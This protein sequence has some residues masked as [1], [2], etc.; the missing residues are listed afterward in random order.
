MNPAVGRSWNADSDIAMIG[1]FLDKT[2]DFYAKQGKFANTSAETPKVFYFDG[3]AESL[4]I[5]PRAVFQYGL[6]VQNV[7]NLVYKRFSKYLLADL[8]K[9]LRD[10][11]AKNNTEYAELVAN[12]GIDGIKP[13]DVA[14]NT[15]SEDLIKSTPDI[16]TAP[17]IE[18]FLEDFAGIFNTKILG[19]ELAAIHNAG[20]YNSGGTVNADLGATQIAI[21]DEVAANILKKANGALEESFT[22][23]LREKNQA[24]KIPIL[25]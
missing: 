21:V 7:E 15:L 6:W 1:D 14:S 3:F 2:H 10:Y 9:A 19:E 17:I 5:D 12:L 8:N 4:S 24:R 11:D 23:F 13:E 20:R 22:D 16:H 25:D 18:N